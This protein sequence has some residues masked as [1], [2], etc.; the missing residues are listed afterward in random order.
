MKTFFKNSA[1]NSSS[2]Q[3][4]HQHQKSIWNQ[5]EITWR[6]CTLNQPPQRWGLIFK[7]E[8]EK[9]FGIYYTALTIDEIYWR[10]H[11]MH[12][13]IPHLDIS[14]KTS[15]YAS[16]PVDFTEM[17]TYIQLF[18]IRSRPR[19]LL[20]HEEICLYCMIAWIKQKMHPMECG[21]LNIEEV[22]LQS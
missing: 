10:C 14:M 17:I 3:N 18:L 6:A 9:C 4:V 5:R 15:K 16:F 1:P 13:F 22:V 8:T 21:K 19:L 20:E 11:I 12:Q 2:R 7:S